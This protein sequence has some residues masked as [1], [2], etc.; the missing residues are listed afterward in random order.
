[1]R[2]GKVQSGRNGSGAQVARSSRSVAASTI[3]ANANVP[4]QA[5]PT[6]A[7]RVELGARLKKFRQANSWTL[8][9]ASKLT[10]V[11]RS[12][13][14]KIEN[15]LMSP[16]YDLLRRIT[17]KMRIDL[18]EL[19]NAPTESEPTGRRSVTRKGEGK[20]L[21][22]ATYRHELIA[23]DVAKKKMLP[24]KSRITARSMAEF[25]GWTRHDG[26]EV[27][28]VMSGAVEVH[29]EYYTPVVLSAGDSIYFDSR[30]GHAVISVS[31]KD[32]EVLWVCS[33]DR[34]ENAV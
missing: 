18:V 9:D 19:F 11:S 17:M 27:L 3:A 8:E 12:T 1:M 23:V 22:T 34:P 33:I 13:L 2:R 5:A 4:L 21:S 31:V 30:M 15:G 20:P 24:F 14:S 32:A 25:D 26:E 16:T 7:E 29:T 6:Q 28:V 10:E